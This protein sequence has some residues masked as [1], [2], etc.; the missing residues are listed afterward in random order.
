MFSANNRPQSPWHSAYCCLSLSF[1]IVCCCLST[2][3]AASH[4]AF[5]NPPLCP[6]LLLPT[7]G[8]GVG[9]N[10]PRGKRRDA[11]FSCRSSP[12]VWD[13]HVSQAR[14]RQ[15]DIS[16]GW[17][18]PSATH[19]HEAIIFGLEICSVNHNQAPFSQWYLHMR[20]ISP[21]PAV[22]ELHVESPPACTKLCHHLHWCYM[23]GVL[24]STAQLLKHLYAE[25]LITV[26]T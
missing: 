5:G 26:A 7:P 14:S 25:P 18:R 12:Q 2:C 4:P 20:C 17:R 16:L 9:P 6:N 19:R 23:A 11:T 24:A 13:W 10:S 8:S 22:N 21:W 3:P 1:N 15:E